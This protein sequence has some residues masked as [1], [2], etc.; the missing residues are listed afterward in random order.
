[1]FT[2]QLGGLRIILRFAMERMWSDVGMDFQ[3]RYCSVAE[4]CIYPPGADH[5]EDSCMHR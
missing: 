1:M 3:W 2:R 5:T 4:Q